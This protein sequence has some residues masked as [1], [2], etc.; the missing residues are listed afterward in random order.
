MIK[1]FKIL[2]II[3]GVFASI[4]IFLSYGFQT[5]N[6]NELI[7]KK[8]NEQYKKIKLEFKN[9][10]V[11]LDIKDFAIK[12]SL[13]EPKLSHKGDLTNIYQTNFGVSL[14]SVIKGNFEPKFIEVKFSENSFEKS[15][16]LVRDVFLED[17][18]KGY[19]ANKVKKG[20][21][22]GDLKIYNEEAIK[23]EFLGSIKDAFFSITNDL[24]EFQ[25]INANI[26]FNGSE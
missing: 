10:R 12:F 2:F 8:F 23:I 26:E 4:I 20:L 15:I 7:Q 25:N 21:I 9:I 14:F 19:F 24:P 5:S 11:S 6:F 18:Q 3:I 22:K 17:D 16:E 1:K 13:N